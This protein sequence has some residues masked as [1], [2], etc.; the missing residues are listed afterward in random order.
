MVPSLGAIGRKPFAVLALAGAMLAVSVGCGSSAPAPAPAAPGGES[1]PVT[2]KV[3]R[4]VW[5]LKAPPAESANIR[6]ICCFDSWQYRPSHEDLVGMDPN[7]GQ[8]I[9]GLATEWKLDTNTNK[10]VFKLRQGVKFHGDKW[11]EMSADDVAD[12]IR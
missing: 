10:I 5:G 3:N 8:Y 1:G 4:L 2:P 9:P 12:G 11:G 6:T 7:T